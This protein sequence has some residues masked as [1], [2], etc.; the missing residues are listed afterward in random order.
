VYR[1]VQASSAS[2]A[3]NYRDRCQQK[4]HRCQQ[5][6]A[7]YA[8]IFAVQ[9]AGVA[10]CSKVTGKDNLG[11]SHRTTSISFV[12]DMRGC[13]QNEGRLVVVVI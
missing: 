3:G 9:L 11:W 8:V 5:K 10:T 2:D 1:C 4:K 6:K 13:Q 7:G 12:M